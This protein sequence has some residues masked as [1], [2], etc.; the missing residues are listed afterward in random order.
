MK[1]NRLHDLIGQRLV[2]AAIGVVV[3]QAALIAAKA[4]FEL[5]GRFHEAGFRVVGLA[6]SLEDDAC[7]EMNDAV[8]GKA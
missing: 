2:A 1:S 7:I 5:L 4:L 8:A 6:L 3:L